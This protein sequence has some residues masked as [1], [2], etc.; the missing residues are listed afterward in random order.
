MSCFKIK[1]LIYQK[2]PH[3]FADSLT[4]VSETFKSILDK[5]APQIQYFVDSI[6][7]NEQAMHIDH[8]IC[9]TM[10]SNCFA[11]GE[12][13]FVDM[14]EYLKTKISHFIPS[15]FVNAY[16][17][18]SWGY[19]LSY[20]VKKNPLSKYYMITIMD[21]NVYNLSCLNHSTDWGHSGYGATTLLIEK[22]GDIKDELITGGAEVIDNP[23]NR[24]VMAVYKATM[25]RKDK[26]LSLPFFLDEVMKVMASLLKNLI[27]LPNR[28]LEWGHCFGSDP[29]ISIIQDVAARPKLNK[30][31]NY[32]A[33][34][35]SLHGFYTFLEIDI[36]PESI[37]KLI[38]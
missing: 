16:E 37:V 9:S 30:E 7:K 26:I 36:T 35:Y 20:L 19:V 34:S 17:C 3:A 6:P 38:S 8:I 12:I 15:L 10:I 21:A 1:G 14:R 18:A 23:M 2:F 13:R 32:F 28:Y 31:I 11:N 4:P 5:L 25:S 33:C 24:F 29:W 22:K 27:V